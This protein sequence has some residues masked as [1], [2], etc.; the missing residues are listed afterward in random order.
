LV[1]FIPLKLARI[2]VIVKT[3]R[4]RAELLSIATPQSNFGCT[5]ILM[6][7]L[8]VRNQNQEWQPIFKVR[9][10]HRGELIHA[11][12]QAQVLGLTL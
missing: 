8:L 2:K 4:V 7:S 5:K 12:I 1:K 6:N 9:L 3:Q 11:H 10:N